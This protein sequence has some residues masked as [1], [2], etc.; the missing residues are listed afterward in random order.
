ML[1]FQEFLSVYKIEFWFEL[2][3]A[4][5][6]QENMGELCFGQKYTVMSRLGGKDLDIGY[7]FRIEVLI[8][9]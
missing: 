1:Q 8:C 2:K 5:L 6:T 9:E 7:T 3:I 4:M